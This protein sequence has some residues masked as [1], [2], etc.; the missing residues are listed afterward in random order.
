M[1]PAP[2]AAKLAANVLPDAIPPLRLRPGPD[3]DNRQ[4][5]DPIGA[6]PT[7]DQTFD[8][9]AP[10]LYRYLAVRLSDA[11][12]A[13]DF[14]QQL[15]LQGHQKAGRIPA[16]Q[17]EFWLRAIARNLIRT[18]WRQIAR[19]PAQVPVPDP[20]LAAETARRLVSEVIP[21]NELERKE[22]RDQL[23]LAITAL[24]AAEQELIVGHYF[25]QLSHAQLAKRAGISE[26]A[27]EG[28]LY[29]ARHSLRT[30]LPEVE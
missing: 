14:L 22:I 25:D 5:A 17:V 2:G 7:F 16:D 21:P 1:T 9:I 30:Q 27:V 29:R 3:A 4:P 15:W 12:L 8:R 19:R 24:P 26:R 18:H 20:A 11:H 10:S 6:A 23:L 28:R 13:E